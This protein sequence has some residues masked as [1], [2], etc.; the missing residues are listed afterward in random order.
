MMQETTVDMVRTFILAVIL[1]YMLLSAILESFAQPVLIL[2]TVP[3]ALIGVVLSLL[4][5]GQTFNI[6]SMMSIIML[7]GIVV[8]NAILIMDYVNIKRRDGYS[9]HDA[10]MEAGKMKLKPIVMSTLAII[11][12]MLPMAIGI[13]STGAEM[14]RPMGIVSIGGLVVSTFLTLIIIPAFYFITTK[15]IHAKN[16]S[17]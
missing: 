10:L 6:V 3:L 1:T 11:F 17:Q 9:V 15:N 5:A 16:E 8:N 7:V 12:G 4:I 2:A 14:T 13:G